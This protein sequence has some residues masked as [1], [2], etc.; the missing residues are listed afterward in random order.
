MSNTIWGEVQSETTTWDESQSG[1]NPWSED[2]AFDD[3]IKEWDDET[4]L[5]D[6]P[7]VYWGGYVNED[8]NPSKLQTT[9]W[10]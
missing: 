5:Y 10:L 2:I 1:I 9:I 8:R 7:D 6:D 3:S 4:V